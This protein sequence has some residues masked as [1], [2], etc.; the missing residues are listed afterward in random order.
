MFADF[1]PGRKDELVEVLQDIMVVN[2][3]RGRSE[4]TVLIM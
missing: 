3:I 4:E 2:E 1:W